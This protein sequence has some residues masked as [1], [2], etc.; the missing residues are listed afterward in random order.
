MQWFCSLLSQAL[1]LAQ[2]HTNCPFGTENKIELEYVCEK[3]H[4]NTVYFSPIKET[5]DRATCPVCDARYSIPVQTG[6]SQAVWT[7]ESFSHPPTQQPKAIFLNKTRLINTALKHQSIK[8][9]EHLY[10]SS[11]TCAWTEKPALRQRRPK[12]I[13]YSCQCPLGF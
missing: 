9:Q 6:D 13:H 10:L 5:P 8:E 12:T 7:T 1:F 3:F 4:M 2:M 11:T